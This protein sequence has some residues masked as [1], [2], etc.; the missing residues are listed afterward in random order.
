ME[1]NNSSGQGGSQ[2][3]NRVET[4]IKPSG[5]QGQDRG[6]TGGWIGNSHL[7]SKPFFE[8]LGLCTLK[9]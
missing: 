1:S 9:E 2:G 4:E 3:C 5:D 8:A 6:K 7:L